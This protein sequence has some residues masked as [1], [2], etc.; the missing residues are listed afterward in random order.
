MKHL[1]ST[2]LALAFL[3]ANAFGDPK[4]EVTNP[5][6]VEMQKNIDQ[7]IKNDPKFKIKPGD[8]AKKT[9]APAAAPNAPVIP[10]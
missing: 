10:K 9:E 3:S 1:L 6:H 5:K 8:P 7:K 4:V 2:G